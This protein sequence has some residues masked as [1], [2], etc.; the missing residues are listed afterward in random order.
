MPPPQRNALVPV[1]AGRERIGE[2]MSA[3]ANAQD[4]ESKA[5]LTSALERGAE[6]YQFNSMVRSKGLQ[7]FWRRFHIQQVLAAIEQWAA[8]NALRPRNVVTPFLTSPTPPPVQWTALEPLPLV[9]APTP[10]PSSPPA[11]PLSNK[12]ESLIDNLINDLISLRGL[13]AVVGP[14]Q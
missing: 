1:P 5:L 10:Q 4:P 11:A 2:W 6:I 14:R 7:R 12:L 13:L 9:A 3:F 8:A